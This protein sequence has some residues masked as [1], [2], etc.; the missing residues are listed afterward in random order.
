MATAAADSDD[1]YAAATAVAVTVDDPDGQ[2][3][4]AAVPNTATAAIATTTAVDNLICPTRTHT[5]F[6]NM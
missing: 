2:Y 5:L 6:H 1:D 3:R 4:S